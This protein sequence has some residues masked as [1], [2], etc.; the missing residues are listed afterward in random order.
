MQPGKRSVTGGAVEVWRTGRKRGRR[1]RQL[2]VRWS[3]REV[4]P[5][6]VSLT[7]LMKLIPP[8]VQAA[9]LDNTQ[10]SSRAVGCPDSP[11]GFAGNNPNHRTREK[12]K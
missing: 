4:A 3:G 11:K 5:T 8:C 2:L 7:L 9:K 12:K 6:E 10:R 1:S